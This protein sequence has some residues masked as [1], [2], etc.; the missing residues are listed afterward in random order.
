MF[1]TAEI[2]STLARLN[3]SLIFTS[4]VNDPEKPWVHP[5]P[6]PYWKPPEAAVMV[7]KGSAVVHACNL[8]W[9]GNGWTRREDDK[10]AAGL[11]QI[12]MLD[13]MEAA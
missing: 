2:R 3:G 13:R 12:V 8:V 10:R 5:T 6:G 7:K 1:T 4:S 11:L 9:G